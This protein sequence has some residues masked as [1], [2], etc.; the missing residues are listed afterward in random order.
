[1]LLLGDRPAQ[2]A[3]QMLADPGMLATASRAKLSLP[4]SDAVWL[5]LRQRVPVQC[6]YGPA[7]IPRRPS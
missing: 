6:A 2:P 1:V 7:Q 3:A 5:V 4:G